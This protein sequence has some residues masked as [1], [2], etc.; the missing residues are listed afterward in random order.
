MRIGIAVPNYGPLASPEIIGA[1]AERVEASGLDS[2]WVSDHLLAPVGVKSIY[3]Y[4]PRPQPT[5]SD[6][7]VLEQMY[8]PLMTLGWLAGRTQR[9]RLGVSAY[10][11]PYRNPVVTAKLV[12]TLDALSGGR[13]T[14][15]VGSGWLRE[16]FAALH[17]PF[18]NRG[19]RL[20]EYLAICDALWAGG[21]AHYEGN[22]YQ[23]P[24]V[25]TGPRPAQH[26]RPPIWVAG[27]SG[28]VIERAARIGDGWHPID[29]P[30]AELGD[31]VARLHRRLDKIG[32]PRDAVAIT[33]RA[34]VVVGEA[35]GRQGRLLHGDV[36]AI[37]ADLDAYRA[38]GLEH[39]VVGLRREA[40]C[41]ALLRQA[42]AV[43]TA[44]GGR[45]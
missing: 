41:D 30:P 15:A 44:F 3:P 10:I 11:V 18:S 13:L 1:L 31:G 16:E 21:E 24:L 17:V 29:L 42:D 22:Y 33:L 9:V 38:A 35:S 7:T 27:N 43:I 6:V 23:L 2:V 12:A 32:R 5:P 45:A 8:E 20:E 40:T 37:R 14:L 34:S 39:L 36:A 26:P 19:R 28:R 25:R 4:D